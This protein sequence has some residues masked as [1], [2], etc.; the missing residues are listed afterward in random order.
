NVTYCNGPIFAF[1]KERTDDS[2]IPLGFFRSEVVAD[3]G[4]KGV[5]IGAPA[6]ILSRYGKGIILA[7]SPHPEET[8]GL[9]QVELHAIRWLYE[10]RTPPASSGSTWRSNIR[11]AEPQTT[12]Q[13]T[14][15]QT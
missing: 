7:I 3:G 1:P 6:M 5:M 12:P 4:T 10:H 15:S 13:Q 11:A 2:F 8:P 14:K 9:K